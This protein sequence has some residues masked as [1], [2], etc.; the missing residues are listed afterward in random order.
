MRRVLHLNDYP[1]GTFGGAEVLMVRTV[2]LLRAAGWD[3]RTF[4]Q[5]DLPDPRLTAVRY[6]DNRVA[7]QALRRILANFTPD[8]VHLHNYYHVLSP[9][10]LAEL[11]RYKRRLTARVVMYAHDFHLVC[12]NSGATWFRRGELH[13]ADFDRAR[14]WS[15]LLGRRWDYRGRA[16]S[17]LKLL[18]HLWYYRLGGDRRRAI[19]LVL[20]PSRFMQEAMNRSGRPTAHLPYPNP[21]FESRRAD[22]PAELTLIFAGRIE[23]EKGLVQFLQMFPADFAG[24]FLVVGEGV[25]RGA[26]ED[27][28]RRRGLSDRVEFLGRRTHPE[29]MMLIAGAHVLVLPSRWYEN[30]PLSMLEALAAGT[31][32]LVTDRGGMREIVEDAGAGYRFAP[33]DPASVAEQLAKI[34]A[35]HKA[36]TLNSFDVTG[37]LTSRNE[38]AYVDRLL[39]V[40]AGEPA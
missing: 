10:I 31:N 27:V 1:G 35:A 29:T 40:Y 9:A 32:L 12:P 4:T 23:P 11:E 8:V 30:Y 17:V 33:D 7:R 3:A 16:Y 20:C 38:A 24:R 19:D 37:F 36:G 39:R 18:Q 26:A 28:C 6:L 22:R 25:E 34:T 15:Y 21:P 14:S 5:A 13:L 2:G